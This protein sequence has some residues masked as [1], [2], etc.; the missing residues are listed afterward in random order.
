MLDD[1]REARHDHRVYN[2]L[3][4]YSVNLQPDV[5]FFR[6]IAKLFPVLSAVCFFFW[7]GL[8]SGFCLPCVRLAFHMFIRF[9]LAGT[10]ACCRATLKIWNPEPKRN[11]KPGLGFR[12]LAFFFEHFSAAKS[13][14]H[15]LSILVAF[16]RKLIFFFPQNIEINITF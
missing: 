16:S 11:R 1:V 12:M 9:V 7:F 6:L 5:Y 15:Y 3:T 13:I 10:P 8:Y 4:Y 2:V 14:E